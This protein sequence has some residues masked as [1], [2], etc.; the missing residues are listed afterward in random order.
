MLGIC[1]MKIFPSKKART[2]VK[3]LH[4]GCESACPRRSWD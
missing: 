4:P 2:V 3:M 1:Q